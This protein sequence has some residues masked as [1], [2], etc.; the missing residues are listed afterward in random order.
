LEVNIRQ[1]P[2]NFSKIIVAS[3]A[4][5]APAAE[6]VLFNSG[7]IRLDDVLR[8]PVTQYDIIRTLPFGGSIK[9][10]D[11]KGSLVVRALDA[12]LR[13]RGIGGF[14][15]YNNEVT[16][17]SVSH[18][19]KLKGQPINVEKTYHTA[20]PEF[21]LTGK[22]SNIEFLNPSNPEVIKVYDT[23]T[24]PA[25]SRSDVRLAIIRYMEKMK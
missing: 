2:T 5:A 12:G 13:N 21:L 15:Q 1:R 3:I 24:S 11:L 10:A 25:D 20:M 14:L 16:F 17:D 7:S 23:P 18:V 8:P 22:E 19:W 9:E 6:I 4:A